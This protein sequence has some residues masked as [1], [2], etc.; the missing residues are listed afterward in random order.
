MDNPL[1]LLNAAFWLVILV[2]IVAIRLV[3]AGLEEPE[4]DES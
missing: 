2:W 1:D 4:P 3:L